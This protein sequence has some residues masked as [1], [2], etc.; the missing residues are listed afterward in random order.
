MPYGLDEDE[1][2]PPERYAGER[3]DAERELRRILAL[4]REDAGRREALERAVRSRLAGSRPVDEVLERADAER[5]RNNGNGSPYP[6]G[7]TELAD[8]ARS[9]AK[10]G[11][12]SA[13]LPGE[14]DGLGP[15]ARKAGTVKLRPSLA[16]V[17]SSR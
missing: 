14:T 4:C 8:T 6:R 2:R 13:R 12:K 16:R 5:A 11:R 15:D 17:S 1:W 9:L 7:W 3:P 10:P